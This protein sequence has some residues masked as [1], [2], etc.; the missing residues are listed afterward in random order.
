MFSFT[1]ASDAAFCCS[2]VTESAK[3][4]S[5]SP[6]MSFL[7]CP[8][9]SSSETSFFA[10]E[11]F[12]PS[13]SALNILSRLAE[14]VLLSIFG[15]VPYDQS[16]DFPRASFMTAETSLSSIAPS[17]FISVLPDG[18]IPLPFMIFFLY[19]ITSNTFIMPS[20][21]ISP[22]MPSFVRDSMSFAFCCSFSSASLLSAASSRSF[23]SS[24]CLRSASL[25]SSSVGTFF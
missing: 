25:R 20:P 17:L 21:F 7:N 8:D 18:S 9:T 3:I 4:I 22:R 19:L 15:I 10:S 14:T 1:P 16:T 13:I 5:V 11:Y 2:S 6:E 24:A 12:K 23:S